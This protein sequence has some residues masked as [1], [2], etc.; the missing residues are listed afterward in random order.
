MYIGAFPEY[1][2]VHQVHVCCSWGRVGCWVVAY[3]VGTGNPIC[4]FVRTDWFLNQKSL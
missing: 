2:A 4:S 1:I 3:C